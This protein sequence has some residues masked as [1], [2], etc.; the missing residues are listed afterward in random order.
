MGIFKVEFLVFKCLAKTI[1]FPTYFVLYYH[2]VG[3]CD[4]LVNSINVN[5]KIIV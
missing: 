4:M 1:D 2:Y 3:S 5:L